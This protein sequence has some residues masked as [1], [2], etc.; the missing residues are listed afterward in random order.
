MSD[1]CS[2]PDMCPGGNCPGCRN[3]KVWCQDPR[4]GPYCQNCAVPKSFDYNANAVFLVI[5]ICLLAALFIVWFVYGPAFF[6]AHSDHERANV[7]VPAEMN[8]QSTIDI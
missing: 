5:L 3:G 1:H 7:I 4:C 8:E 2:N 6:R